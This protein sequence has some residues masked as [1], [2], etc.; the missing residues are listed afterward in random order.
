MTVQQGE[1]SAQ[2]AKL[3]R[4]IKEQRLQAM[5]LLCAGGGN[6]F[7][8]GIGAAKNGYFAFFIIIPI[9]LLVRGILMWKCAERL[10]NFA[11]T[12]H[13]HCRSPDWT[14]TF[15]DC[16]VLNPYDFLH[17]AKEAI[18]SPTCVLESRGNINK[19]SD[20]SKEREQIEAETYPLKQ[21]ADFIFTITNIIYLAIIALSLAI[22]DSSN[23]YKFVEWCFL[24]FF[25][26]IGLPHTTPILKILMICFE[27]FLAQ[28]L[29]ISLITGVA[30]TL[31]SF[32]TMVAITAIA[33]YCIF[34]I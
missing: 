24:W 19:L 25:A 32:V 18:V 15:N 29:V 20:Y 26:F 12:H 31:I 2:W 33:A 17:S 21:R 16:V 8:L 9:F 22:I 28:M 6:L 13:G 3:N 1:M 4:G 5:G 27:C 23:I 11:Y 30:L 34:G 10:G 7:V 14:I